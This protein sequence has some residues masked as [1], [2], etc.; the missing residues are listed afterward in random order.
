[1]CHFPGHKNVSILDFIGAKD[2][3]GG[4]DNWNYRMCKTSVRSPPTW[5]FT[6]QMPFLSPNPIVEALKGKTHEYTNY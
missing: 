4:G 2:G 1:M 3:G 5:N 6:G